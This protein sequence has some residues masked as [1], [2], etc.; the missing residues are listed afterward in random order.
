[1][2]KVTSFA[3]LAK[4]FRLMYEALGILNVTIRGKRVISC[5]M[6]RSRRCDMAMIQGK[7]NGAPHIIDR[8]WGQAVNVVCRRS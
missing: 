2:S 5:M 1:M 7:K 4:E 8:G 3:S 6:N